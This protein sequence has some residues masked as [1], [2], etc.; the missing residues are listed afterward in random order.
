MTIYFHAAA[1]LL[2]PG[3]IIEPEKWGYS[4]A[5]YR[6]VDMNQPGMCW[7]LFRETIVEQVRRE[8]YPTLPSRLNAVFACPT[9]EALKSLSGKFVFRLRA[10]QPGV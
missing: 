9:L 5:G 7:S 3:A 2:A 6:A 10:L 8:R 4:L 1:T